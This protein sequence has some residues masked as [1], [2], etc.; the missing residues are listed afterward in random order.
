MALIVRWIICLHFPQSVMRQCRLQA[1]R[2]AVQEA[3]RQEAVQDPAQDR[4]SE[5]LAITHGRII[6]II[7]PIVPTIGS[8]VEATIGRKM[9]FPSSVPLSIRQILV[10]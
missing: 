7:R 4:A 5:F 3:V 1:V 8:V 9:L 2:E 6:I 10:Q